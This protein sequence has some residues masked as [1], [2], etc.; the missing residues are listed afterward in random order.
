MELDG[1]LRF[2]FALIAVLGLIALVPAIGRRFGFVPRP[3]RKGQGRL[4]VVE[5]ATLDARRRLVLVRRDGVEHLLL[6]GPETET[7][8]ESGIRPPAAGA[9]EP[10]AEPAATVT[11]FPAFAPISN[12]AER[13]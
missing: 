12:R 1:Y 5:V 10:A 6:L 13:S 4:G 3:G 7:V 2:V 8:V 11:P 9:A